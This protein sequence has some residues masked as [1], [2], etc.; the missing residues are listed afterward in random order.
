MTAKTKR[1]LAQ[2]LSLEVEKGGEQTLCSLLV[3]EPANLQP[4]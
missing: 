4:V 1:K 3:F 2:L